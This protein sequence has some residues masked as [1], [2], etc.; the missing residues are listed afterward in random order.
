MPRKAATESLADRDAAEGGVAA[1]DRALSLMSVF[2]EGDA[3]LSLIEL[4][5]RTQLY[6]STVLRLLASLMHA[7]WVQRL[8]DGRFAL[9]PEIARLHGLYAASFSLERIV[10]PVLRDLVAATGES[11]AYHVRQGDARLCLY[12]VDSPHPVR[13]H[14]RAG[15]LL[16]LDRGTG[17]RVLTAFDPVLGVAPGADQALYA[18]IRADGY[19]VAVGDRLAEVAGISAPVFLADGGVAAA[20]TLTAPV[21]RHRH[22]HL[23][24][25]LQAARRLSGKVG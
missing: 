2:G 25:V 19:I 3:S 24:A 15:D 23:E 9:G 13:D 12:R 11:A 1:V 17:G 18:R 5:E 20:V 16:P 14:I 21:H 6:K 22:A 8:E 7:G 4:A 10:M